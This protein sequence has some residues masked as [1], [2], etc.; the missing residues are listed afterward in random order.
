MN[1]KKGNPD[2]A[3]PWKRR[4]NKQ[5]LKMALGYISGTKALRLDA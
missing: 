1:M 2:K 4:K 3:F 5:T